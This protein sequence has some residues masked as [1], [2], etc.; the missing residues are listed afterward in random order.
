MKTS[1]KLP[2]FT[3]GFCNCDLCQVSDM[4][5]V[6]CSI[7]IC[8]EGYFMFDSKA[9]IKIYFCNPTFQRQTDKTC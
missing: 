4:Y 5:I 6:C 7:I 2:V 8:S 9:S 1:E 3:E